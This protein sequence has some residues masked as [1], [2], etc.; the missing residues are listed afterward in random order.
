[1]K[2]NSSI[3]A[4]HMRRTS[5]T[6]SWKDSLCKIENVFLIFWLIVASF[7]A[8]ISPPGTGADEATHIARAAQVA[9]GAF[10]PQEVDIAKVDTRFVTPTEEYSHE[11][12]YGGSTDAALFE[13]LRT[14]SAIT[15]QRA[16]D[17]SS[18][19]LVFP[20]WK[21]GIF[22]SIGTLG[23]GEVIWSFP[24]TS[25]NSP[26]C[27][28]PYSIGYLIAR[29]VS[30]SPIFAVILMRLLG[31]ISYG[32]L[33]WFAIKKAPFCKN[34]L[35]FLAL[36]PNC[37]AVNSMVTADMLTIAFT[38]LFFSYALRFLFY[39]KELHRKDFVGFGISLCALALLKMPY[40]IFGLVL[41]LIFVVNRLW[42][43]KRE[44]A[45]IASI[46]FVALALFLAWSCAIHGI[47]TYTAWTIPSVDPSAQLSY[48]LNNPL[49]TLSLI[50]DNIV[51]NTDLGL[52]E[53]TAYC[54]K[55]YP[56]WLILIA[57]VC[58]ISID[59]HNCPKL[60]LKYPVVVFF[61]CITVLVALT[62][63]FALY[64]TYTP[65]GDS[66]IGGMQSRY[67]VPLLIPLFIALVLACSNNKMSLL[68]RPSATPSRWNALADSRRAVA[69]LQRTAAGSQRG[70]VNSQHT[71]AIDT[72][73][74]VVGS[75]QQ[76]E[77]TASTEGMISTPVAVILVFWFVFALRIFSVWLPC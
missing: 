44:M 40:I 57:A 52:F 4:P 65:V 51:S 32:L 69:D 62:A 61:L 7:A 66:Q 28:V 3:E 60:R 70:A 13:L 26:L 63:N 30:T 47:R 15:D 50:I 12:I 71:A 48:A 31:I 36:L 41:F 33:V 45:K 27:Y 6:L 67:Y 55:N 2:R 25:I 43:N 9:Q 58:I 39:Y 18:V 53:A 76:A 21:D 74:L 49:Q 23:N 34:T 16:K 29:L 11:K 8:I 35:F 46:G 56:E 10:L 68:G 22:A 17:I 75:S 5:P 14:G 73:H 77:T 54:T 19:S 38:F 64:L 1:M 20:Y 72:R 59:V 42:E 24:N 37:I